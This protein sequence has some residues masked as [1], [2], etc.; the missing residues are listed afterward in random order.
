MV[1]DD[2]AW[3]LLEWISSSEGVASSNRSGSGVRSSS[4]FSTDFFVPSFSASWSFPRTVSSDEGRTFCWCDSK[5]I[6]L[7]ACSLVSGL[8]TFARGTKSMSSFKSVLIWSTVWCSSTNWWLLS[9]APFLTTKSSA[10][11]T[12]KRYSRKMIPAGKRRVLI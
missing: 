6:S 3:L 4:T 2:A 10:K 12:D 11:A 7:F 9:S 5:G 8:S 1:L